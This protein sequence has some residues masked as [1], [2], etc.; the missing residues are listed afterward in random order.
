MDDRQLII[1]TENGIAT[2]AFNRPEALNALNMDLIAEF[3]I[4]LDNITKDESIRVLVLTGAGD[5]AFVAGADINELSQCGPLKA[6]QCSTSGQSAIDKLQHLPIPVIA[7]VNGFALG[8]GCELALACDFIYASETAMFGLPEITL[9]LIPG[10]GGTQRLPRLIGA[11]LAKELI[12][13]GRMITAGEAAKIGIVNRVLPPGELMDATKKTARTIA[14]K[15]KV[16]LLAAKQAINAGLNV[17][18]STGCT[19]E[20]DGFALCM[21]S[22]DAKEGTR[23]FLEKR[24]AKFEG[25]YVE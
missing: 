3:A 13:T 19:I 5:K 22:E 1:E 2:I 6:K 12:L 4:L 15:G 16:S 24:E 10:F 9:G 14:K 23:A 25:G 11:N 8:G 20:A 7:A 17:D 18:F 21:A